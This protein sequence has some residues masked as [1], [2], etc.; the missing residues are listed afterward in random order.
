M[1]AFKA[2]GDCDEDEITELS[3]RVLATVVHTVE[4]LH[5]DGGLSCLGVFDVYKAVDDAIRTE[6]KK[7]KE[8]LDNLGEHSNI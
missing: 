6:H 5:V 1:T 2:F 8:W 3:H 4:R 7:A